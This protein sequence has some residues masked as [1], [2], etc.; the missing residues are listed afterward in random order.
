MISDDMLHYRFHLSTCAMESARC[1]TCLIMPGMAQASR[2]SAIGAMTC[3]CGCCA[4]V[5]SGTPPP[6]EPGKRCAVDGGVAAR[7]G[8]CETAAVLPEAG[9]FTRLGWTKNKKKDT[10]CPTCSKAWYSPW[11]SAGGDQAWATAAGGRASAGSAGEH[12]W[13]AAAGEWASAGAS[14]GQAWASA[15]TTGEQTSDA[16]PALTVEEIVADTWPLFPYSHGRVRVETTISM[17]TYG[18]AQADTVKEIFTRAMTIS[19]ERG[20]FDA[21]S[22]K[23]SLGKVGLCELMFDDCKG[24]RCA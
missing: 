12:A 23:M 18:A 16:D 6:L 7:C 22:A 8:T 14:D 15:G 13:A 10:W 19:R 21:F 11:A 2:Q 5:P 4:R 17:T 24:G 9:C 1:N 3:P 20:L